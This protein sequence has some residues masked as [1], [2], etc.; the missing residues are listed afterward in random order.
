[1]VSFVEGARAI[2]GFTHVVTGSGV[3]V[4]GNLPILQQHTGS[5]V[6]AELKAAGMN[7]MHL[8]DQALHQA[9]LLVS[10][11]LITRL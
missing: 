1:M 11:L 9:A 6:F 3:P 7:G 10:A 5:R 4:L 2:D 8:S